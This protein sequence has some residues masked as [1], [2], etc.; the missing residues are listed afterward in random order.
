VPR[1]SKLHLNRPRWPRSFVQLHPTS[2]V[3]CNCH[4][5]LAEQEQEALRR[6]RFRRSIVPKEDDVVVPRRPRRV[7]PS[8]WSL[9]NKNGTN[10][11]AFII[12]RRLAFWTATRPMAMDAFVARHTLLPPHHGQS[13]AIFEVEKIFMTHDVKQIIIARRVRSHW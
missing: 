11:P 10:H 6:L 7:L 13:R 3:S 9:A 8:S 4:V 2:F 12:V 1:Q 5:P